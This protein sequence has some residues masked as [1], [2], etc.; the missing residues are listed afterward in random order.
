MRLITVTV[1]ALV[2][3]LS[4]APVS[5]HGCSTS[6]HWTSGQFHGYMFGTNGH[7]GSHLHYW[8]QNNACI[9][10]SCYG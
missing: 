1:A 8:D 5:A 10:S 4:V 9:G 6:S 2:M 7:Q 3:A